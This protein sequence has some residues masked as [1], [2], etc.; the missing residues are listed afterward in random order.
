VY[1]PPAPE[2]SA[3]IDAPWDDAWQADLPNGKPIE[4]VPLKV[5]PTS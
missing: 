5:A 3:R 2:P 1:E 4:P